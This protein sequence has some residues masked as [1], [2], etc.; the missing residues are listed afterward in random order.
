M[1]RSKKDTAASCTKRDCIY[2]NT[3]I[4]QRYGCMYAEK[5]NKSKLSQ[6][7]PGETYSVENCQ[8]Y[9]PGRKRR[10]AEI[11]PPSEKVDSHITS[12]ARKLA[13]EPNALVFYDM[14][15]NDKDIAHIYEVPSQAVAYWRKIQGLGSGHESKRLNW[16]EI[17]KMMKEGYSDIAIAKLTNTK[18]IVIAE[19]RK[20]EAS[21]NA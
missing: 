3:D 17:H 16:R 14:Q 15:L 8:F 11:H 6:I 12:G 1:G 2:Y 10:S 20:T 13:K 18:S 19:Y 4:Y 7:P 21:H 9:T 5:E